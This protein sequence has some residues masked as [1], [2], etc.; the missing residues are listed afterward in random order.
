MSVQVDFRVNGGDVVSAGPGAVIGRTAAAVI[1]LNDPAISEAHALVSLRGAG[2]RLLSL[3]GRFVVAGQ[4]VT[5]V[6]LEPG[7]VIELAPSLSLEVVD[8]VLPGVVLGLEIEG[9]GV[10][11]PPPVASIFADRPEP[12]PG[13]APG[14]DAIVWSADQ[15]FHAR[16]A[17]APDRELKAGQELRVAGRRIAVVAVPLADAATDATDA[18][19]KFAVPLVLVVR[20]DVVHIWRAEV[21]IAVDGIP[22]RILTELALMRVPVEWRTVAREIWPEEAN[23]RRLRMNWDAGIAR[24]RARLREAGIRG[25]LV[26]SAGAGLV[27]IFLGPDDRVTDAA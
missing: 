23:E 16:V 18:H 17:G 19:A 6:L 5:D 24:L 13:I 7:V 20:Y 27:E 3:R 2:L 10:L 11:I 8:V 14:A 9:L 26:R 1:R 4:R 22:G 12:V 21:S 15:S 25:D